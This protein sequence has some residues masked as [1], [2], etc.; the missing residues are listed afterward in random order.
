MMYFPMMEFLD[1]SPPQRR[2]SRSFYGGRHHQHPFYYYNN[3]GRHHHHGHPFHN[4]RRSA[5]CLKRSNSHFPN[6]WL[7]Q[8]EEEPMFFLLRKRS[9]SADRDDNKSNDEENKMSFNVRGFKPED[10]K[11]S[12]DKKQRTVT[13]SAKREEKSDGVVR[14]RSMRQTVK[15]GDNVDMEKVEAK[16]DGD[17]LR[18]EAPKLDNMLEEEKKT[19]DDKD[20]GK[21]DVAA[22]ADEEVEDKHDGTAKDGDDDNSRAKEDAAEE[23]E[24]QIEVQQPQDSF[25]TSVNVS[26]YPLSSLTVSVTDRDYIKVHGRV[27]E[28][29]EEDGSVSVREFSKEVP[30]KPEGRYDLENIVYRLSEDETKLLLE[31]PRK[32]KE[33]VQAVE[34]EGAA[35]PI[36]VV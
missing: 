28:V 2:H 1:A 7:T 32:K 29:D 14:V 20:A 6:F 33:K 18:L 27:E 25:K 4:R 30:A 19:S 26:G 10:V 3:E 34:E 22:K 12:A 31:A 11:I 35:V 23:K 21:D 16:M 24:V 5:A 36:N 9:R 13:V 17:V 8:E 15:V